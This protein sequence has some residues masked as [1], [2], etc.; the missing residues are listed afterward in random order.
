M[1]FLLYPCPFFVFVLPASTELKQTPCFIYIFSYLFFF[2]S[3]S[4]LS[5]FFQL[6]YP[7]LLQLIQYGWAFD[8]GDF[9]VGIGPAFGEYC[10]SDNGIL[11]WN[12]KL[13]NLFFDIFYTGYDPSLRHLTYVYDSFDLLLFILV[14]NCWV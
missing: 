12:L 13:C 9:C 8:W 7:K 1:L 3:R 14:V 6:L 5:S 4:S 11:N 10:I 2:F